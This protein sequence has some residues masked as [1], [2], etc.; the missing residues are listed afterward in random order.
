MWIRGLK[1]CNGQS[2]SKMEGKKSKTKNKTGEY[3]W[4]ERCT[5][6]SWPTMARQ[7]RQTLPTAQ[8]LC[9]SRNPMICSA[10]CVRVS[11]WVSGWVSVCVSEWVSVWVDDWVWGSKRKS[12]SK[13]LACEMGFKNRLHVNGLVYKGRCV[14]LPPQGAALGSLASYKIW[15]WKQ[16]HLQEV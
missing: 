9:G 12:P 14:L 8:R 15:R 11:E 13:M 16:N 10:S 3:A 2:L 5:Y 4:G 6:W 1:G 7:D